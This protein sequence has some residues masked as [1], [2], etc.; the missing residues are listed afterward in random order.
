MHCQVLILEVK[1]QLFSIDYSYIFVLGE[2]KRRFIQ[3]MIQDLD[4]D[5]L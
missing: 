4:R 5:A 3:E 1:R 2:P